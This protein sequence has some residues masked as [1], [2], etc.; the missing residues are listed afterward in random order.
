MV[1][2]MEAKVNAVNLAREV[3]FSKASK[4]L[5][6]PPSTI[7]RW[8]GNV[9]VLC[10]AGLIELP[11]EVIPECPDTWEPSLDN[12]LEALEKKCAEQMNIISEIR[13]LVERATK[14]PQKSIKDLIDAMISGEFS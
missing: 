2:S 7:Y 13:K 6:I 10:E 14:G 9:D 3:G 1:Y 5:G 11:P 12:W 4:Q 8:S